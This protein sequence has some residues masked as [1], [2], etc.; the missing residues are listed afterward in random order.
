MYSGN[1]EQPITATTWE[2]NTP[3]TITVGW[4]QYNYTYTS[5]R[6]MLVQGCVHMPQSGEGVEA[7]NMIPGHKQD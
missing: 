5:T 1:R 7:R 6:Q 3:L 4:Y 2:N